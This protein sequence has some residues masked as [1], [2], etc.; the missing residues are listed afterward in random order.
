MPVWTFALGMPT[1]SR[2]CSEADRTLGGR[3]YM[4]SWSSATLGVT[5]VSHSGGSRCRCPESTNQM[6]SG[7]KS[8][9]ILRSWSKRNRASHRGSAPWF[10]IELERPVQLEHALPHIDQ[11]Q[12][13]GFLIADYNRRHHRTPKDKRYRWT[14]LVGRQPAWLANIWRRCRVLP[15]RCDRGTTR[16]RGIIR[17]HSRPPHTK[18]EC[19]AP[20]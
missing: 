2:V 7:T 16:P 15:A 10:A 11:P 13:S 1:R 9:L 4:S 5:K 3:V 6:W 20:C 19:R 14:G 18:R 17:P 8:G 12:P